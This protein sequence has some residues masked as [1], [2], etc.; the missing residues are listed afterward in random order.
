MRK[1]HIPEMSRGRTALSIVGV[2]LFAALLYAS[3]ACRTATNAQN[4]APAAVPL[5]PT[6][7]RTSF[8]DIVDR[9]GPSVVT[10][11]SERR[12]RAAQQMP[13]MDDETFRQMFGNRMP[14]MQQQPREQVERGLGSG[15]IINSNGTILTNYHV[16]DGA[17]DIKV[18]LT[19]KRTLSAKVIGSDKASDLAVLKV[20]GGNLPALGL[21]DSDKMRVG[22]VV[23]AIGNPLGLQQ[24]VTMGIIS[25][26]DRQTGVGDGSFEDFL[27][28]DAPINHG[29]SGGA[30]I[31]T[32]GELI[33][34]NSQILSPSGG[35]IGIGFAIPS[36]MAKTVMD[37]LIAS[38][39]VRRGQL[40][41]GIQ[42]V[43]SDLAASLGLK[44]VR[45]VIV[46]QVQPG[47]PAERAGI[48]Q[49]DVITS[50]NGAVVNDSNDLRNK[51]AG[52]QPGTQVSL[53]VLRGGR[54]Q[55]VQATL[56]EFKPADE[57]AAA[58][59]N[60]NDG[61]DSG[62]LGVQVEPLTPELAKQVGVPTAT[63]GLVVGAVTPGSPAD[64]AG[65][66]AG[67]VIMQINRQ[68]VRTSADV[69][70]ALA[71]SGDKPALVL[72]NHKGSTVY[73]TVQV[74]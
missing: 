73:L 64:D 41:V 43:T 34:I 33:G 47:S 16:V 42:P 20:E 52:T 14:Q 4:T 69:K 60:S 61:S 59:G 39:K 12:T 65:I 30:L 21:G 49:E 62:L 31:N 36:N 50:F 2:V 8:A 1:F 9:V 22:D 37:Q 5:G 67:D 63:Q 44:D 53:T 72:V 57:Q 27:Q 32:N 28:T 70:A 40:G 25:A 18:D 15:V 24:T 51:V 68:P 19:D 66:T 10:V 46:N 13:F 3:A 54:E 17:E 48:K 71:R 55:Q 11:R 56:G 35:S 26:K 74:K 23:L 7:V 38:G 29:N 6:S 45:G 58:M